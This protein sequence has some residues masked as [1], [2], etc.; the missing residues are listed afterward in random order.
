[1]SHFLSP[2]FFVIFIKKF[3]EMENKLRCTCASD[4]HTLHKRLKLDGGDLFLFTGDFMSSGYRADELQDFVA[5][6]KDYVS[7]LYT[8]VAL[9]AGNHDRMAES[10]PDYQV[11]D[12]FEVADKIHYIKDEA[13]ELEFQNGQK[14]KI[15]GTPMQ[16][17][18][19]NWAFN[20]KDSDK[21]QFIYDSVVEED[22]DILLTHC[23]PFS[24]LDCSHNPRP[25]FGTTGEEHLGSIELYNVIKSREKPPRYHVFGHI[26]GDG[27]KQITIDKTTYINASVCDE[28]YKPINKIVTLEIEGRGQ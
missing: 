6:L 10:F 3:L 22:I 4:T 24:I 28:A 5:W 8:H 21:L 18:F 13:I 11:K 23:P 9:I 25:Q 12:M 20:V 27:G 1:M 16:P 19:C 7:P 17:F 15:A 14:L 26:H 2:L